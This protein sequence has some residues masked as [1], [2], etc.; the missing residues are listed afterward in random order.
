MNEDLKN[1]YI[2]QILNE[3]K[4]FFVLDNMEVFSENDLL[5]IYNFIESVPLG[6]KF[7]LTSRHH[8][9][10]PNFV[11]IGNFDKKLCEEYIK[12]VANEYE[13]SVENINEIWN[14]LD[15]FYYL[16]GGNPLYIRFFISQIK[17]GRTL[18]DI[19]ERHPY[20]GGRQEGNDKIYL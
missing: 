17:K 20:R 14:N 15:S 4:F 19:L 2:N 12:D 5:E 8:I 13:V 11:K 7:L 16:T 1:K 3:Y 9:R 18:K 10:V 6:H